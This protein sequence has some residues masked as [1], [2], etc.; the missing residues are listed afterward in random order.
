MS[1]N[2]KIIK[3][4]GFHISSFIVSK[5]ASF[6]HKADIWLDAIS[7][8]NDYNLT[9][10]EGKQHLAIDWSSAEKDLSN[11]LECWKE[12]DTIEIID[13]N[14]FQIA[15]DKFIYGARSDFLIS[16]EVTCSQGYFIEPVK[17]FLYQLYTTLN[18]S[19]LGSA[20]FQQVTI[21]NTVTNV[22]GNNSRSNPI[23]LGLP[24]E[25]FTDAHIMSEQLE[26]P[27][28]ENLEFKFVWD[29]LYKTKICEANLGRTNLERAFFA[30]WNSCHI[31]VDGTP[32]ELVWLT[33]ALEAF[34]DIQKGDSI[35]ETL[36]S[37]IF[38]FLPQSEKNS[39]VIRKNISA[40]YSLRSKIVH[41]GFKFENP[42]SHV[43]S[44]KEIEENLPSLWNSID[45][46]RTILIAS[47]QKVI[48]N[49]WTTI[50]FET[51]FKSK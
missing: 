45:M 50:E 13:N 10:E 33:L 11:F 48:R 26:W 4:E 38:V 49:G 9:Y 44:D 28:L 46:A 25:G 1:S 35:G 5:T 32:M 8:I 14:S 12:V 43:L 21:E 15:L 36:K 34:Y 20:D 18:L 17:R 23:I 3:A 7:L 51:T 19:D 30:F 41:G 16:F 39:R 40:F 42:A 31:G 22:N 29:W 24:S 27:L 6:E 37:R 47:F 2:T